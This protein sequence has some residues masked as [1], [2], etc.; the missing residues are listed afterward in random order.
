MDVIAGAA[1]VERPD[2]YLHGNLHCRRRPRRGGVLALIW[3]KSGF[4]RVEGEVS[5][6]TV[7]QQIAKLHLNSE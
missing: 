3:I 2:P 6:W 5:Q 7:N 1:P 4:Q